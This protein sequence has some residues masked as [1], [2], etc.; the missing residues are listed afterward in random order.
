MFV[1]PTIVTPSRTATSPG[2]VSSQ[3]PPVSAARS[4]I[5]DPGRIA[6]TAAAGIR[7]GAARPRC[8]RDHGVEVADSRLERG[9]L[10]LLFF[11]TQ[12]ARV[13]ALGLRAADPE[14]EPRRT[15]ALDLLAH[16]RPNVEARHDCAEPA[17]GRDRL[18]A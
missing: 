13:A 6:A 15:E 3:L 14:V 5:T 16:D 9:L 18:Q 10:R 7:R 1:T 4:T 17:R 11:R 2:T 12:L 8:G